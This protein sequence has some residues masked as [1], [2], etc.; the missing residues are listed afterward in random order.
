MAFTACAA[1]LIPKSN[2]WI[3]RTHPGAAAGNGA[4]RG[5]SLTTAPAPAAAS[6]N[7]FTSKGP[8]RASSFALQ[9]QNL[10]DFSAWGSWDSR[11]E[12]SSAWPPCGGGKGPERGVRCA[13]GL[14]SARSCFPSAH[15]EKESRK[16]V[17]FLQVSYVTVNR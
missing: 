17:F 1:E 9:I 7:S 14:L 16:S 4:A 3:L 10:A 5:A 2:S 13:P 8:L 12:T 6:Y 15:R 11:A